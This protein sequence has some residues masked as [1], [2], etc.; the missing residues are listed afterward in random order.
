MDDILVTSND[1]NFLKE[2]TSR[3]NLVFALKDLGSL[4][5]FLGVKVRRDNSGLYLN[6][7]KYILDVLK[8][9]GM[10]NC[11]AIATPM[12]TGRKFSANDGEKMADP[13]LY[14][15]A[16]GSLQYLLTTRLDIVFSINKLSQFLLQHTK[17]HFQGVKQILKYLKGTLQLSLHFKPMQHMRLVAFTNVDWATNLD[18]RRSVGGV[19]VYLNDN[20]VS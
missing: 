10:M 13:T 18:D 12:V 8:R 17:T 5:Y 7:G 1:S 20:L 11:V 2:F 3:L 9:F 16:I 4:Y 15:K 6:Q 19:C 14:R